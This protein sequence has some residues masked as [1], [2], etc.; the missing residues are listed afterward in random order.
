VQSGAV[1]RAGLEE[2]KSRRPGEWT[3][4]I[5]LAIDRDGVVDVIDWKTGRQEHTA[6]IASNWQL[7]FSALAAARAF[8]A[9]TIRAA[10]VYL[11]PGSYWEDAATFYALD[12][13]TIAHELR[14]LRATLTRGPTPP[15]PGPWCT[16]H[17]CPLVGDCPATRAAL[18]SAY[19]LEQ[20]LVPVIRD[21][22]HARFT[23]ERIAG[24]EAA[25]EAIKRAVKDYARTRPVPM[26][27]GRVYAWRKKQ[28]RT[29]RLDTPA[30]IAALRGVL[31]ESAEKAIKIEA[32]ATLEGIDAAARELVGGPGKR[33]KKVVVD[34]ALEALEAVGGLDVSEYEAPGVFEPKAAEGEET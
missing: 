7:R 25:L 10:L 20:P 24:A 30:R 23:L 5:D 29:I 15:V 27:D 9:R 14:E 28:R 19:P 33:G 18:A 32:S 12:L 34:R 26:G 13:A 16:Q 4:K 17:Y 8:G 11:E 2:L 31:G 22:A 3:V 6:E 1:R 21:D